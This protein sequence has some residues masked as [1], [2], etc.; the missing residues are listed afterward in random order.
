MPSLLTFQQHKTD[1]M[2]MTPRPLS[3][4]ETSQWRNFR[5]MVE[6]TGLLVS[7]DMT[8]KTGLAAGEF[9]V[10]VLLSEAP[11]R[12]LRQQQLADLLRWDRTRLAH[13]LKRAEA[14]GL[15]RRAKGSRVSMVRLTPHGAALLKKSLPIHAQAVRNHF[16]SLLTKRQLK[17]LAEVASVL[18][19]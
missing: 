16:F 13:Q 1:A 5:Y 19:V 6:K 2:E 9:A 12:T 17:V 18:D 3:P 10:L 8:S 15:V 14:R 11:G 4:E 7:R